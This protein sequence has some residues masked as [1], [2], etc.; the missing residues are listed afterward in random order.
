MVYLPVYEPNAAEQKDPALYAA[1]V[2]AAMLRAG[3]LQPSEQTL[4][5][6]RAYQQALLADYAGKSKRA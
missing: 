4:A 2:R 1:G 3:D 6:K 5:D